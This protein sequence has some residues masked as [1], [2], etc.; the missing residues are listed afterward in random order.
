MCGFG[1]A[2]RAMRADSEIRD[3]E[4]AARARRVPL[5]YQDA[6]RTRRARRCGAAP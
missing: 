1:T 5:N 6:Q 2:A 4:R 3:A